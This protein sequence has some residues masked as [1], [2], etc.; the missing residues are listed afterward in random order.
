[1]LKCGICLT[2]RGLMS[3]IG[4]V[5]TLRCSECVPSVTSPPNPCNWCQA[6]AHENG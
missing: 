1:M 4:D 3:H 2:L 6:Q 5:S